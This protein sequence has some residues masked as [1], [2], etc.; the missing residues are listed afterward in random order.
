MLYATKYK[1]LKKKG[2]Q[3]KKTKLILDFNAIQTIDKKDIT[4]AIFIIVI[5]KLLWVF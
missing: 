2:S 1:N 4:F 3:I 5:L